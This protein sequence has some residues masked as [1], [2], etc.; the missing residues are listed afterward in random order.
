MKAKATYFN[1][2]VRNRFIAKICK[3]LS[4]FSEKGQ[5]PVRQLVE[6]L[7]NN[8]GNQCDY[9]K[10]YFVSDTQDLDAI[11]KLTHLL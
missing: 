8:L 1:I 3:N 4:E 5:A 9:E 11:P 10:S 2:I 6:N 7:E